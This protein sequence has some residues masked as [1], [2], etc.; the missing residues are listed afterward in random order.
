MYKRQFFLWIYSREWH[1][2]GTV[3]RLIEET[4]QSPLAQEPE[5]FYAQARACMDWEGAAERLRSVTIPTLVV[6]GDADITCPPRLSQPILEAMPH[7]EPVVIHGGAHQPF[8][9]KPGEYNATLA[10]F[11]AR[12]E[13][14]ERIAAAA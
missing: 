8:Q 11:W 12:V 3:D 9:E 5:A 4:L 2:D 14:A 7:A 13:R 10:R 6:C 1:E